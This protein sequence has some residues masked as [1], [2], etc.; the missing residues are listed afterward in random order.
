[1]HLFN[2]LQ[3]VND[4]L[5]LKLC[6]CSLLSS[7]PLQVQ[8]HCIYFIYGFFF[9]QIPSSFVLL[10][11]S[12][13]FQSNLVCMFTNSALIEW[14]YCV[15]SIKYVCASAC[16]PVE[17]SL[18]ICVCVL[19]VFFSLHISNIIVILPFLLYLR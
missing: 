7:T 1:M 17:N 12:R 18:P 13:R 10:R 6:F 4:L 14:Q 5:H 2:T 15:C 9:L 16:K 8:Q 3:R 11:D 19:N